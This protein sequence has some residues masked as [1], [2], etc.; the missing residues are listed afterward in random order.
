M[1]QKSI[2]VNNYRIFLPKIG[3]GSFSK[4]YAA[5]H[6]LTDND[7]AIKVVNTKF[8]D[9]DI[10]KRINEEIKLIAELKNDNIVKF[11][12]TFLN[13][14]YVYIVTD[15]YPY[16]LRSLIIKSLSESQ[17][18]Q[19][20]IQIRNGLKY[21]M[22]NQIL[23]RDLKPEN[24]LLTSDGTIKIIDFGFAKYF[25]DKDYMFSTICGTPM[26]MAPECL[27]GK[28]YN[29]LSDLWSVGIIFYQLL[30][31]RLPYEQ[32]KNISELVKKIQ[33]DIQIPYNISNSCKDL[34]SRLLTIN[35]NQRIRWYDFFQHCWFDESDD[36]NVKSIY[37]KNIKSI[38][39]KFNNDKIINDNKF[40][41]IAKKNSVDLSSNTNIKKITKKNSAEL[42]SDT[43]IKKITKENSAELSSDTTKSEIIKIGNSY[44]IEDYVDDSILKKSNIIVRS[45]YSNSE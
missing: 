21:L 17:V 43:N 15:L 25:V 42:P 40:N 31:N 30:F 1:N 27:T 36:K 22:E 39:D 6:K 14:G 41:N 4:V 26:Y 12:E 34:L 8:L 11:R 38:N 18:R 10:M 5:K 32:V 9:P 37:N 35:P 24:I 20:M 16:N 28:K 23:H 3:K 7:V 13:L 19:V 2:D 33:G 44:I 45:K 29:V